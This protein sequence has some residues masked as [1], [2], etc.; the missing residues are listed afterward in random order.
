MAVSIYIPTNREEDSLFCIPSPTFIVCRFF[1]D[2]HS[3]L[4]DE[5]LIVVLISISLIISGGEH[6]FMCCWPFVCLRRNV[7]SD[8]WTTVEL[9]CW[10]L[11]SILDIKP[12]AGLWFANIFCHYLGCHL[13]LLRMSCDTRK[14][15]IFF[16]DQCI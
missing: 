1:D 15:L 4:C 12:E 9:C 10:L 2:G 6:L 14:F 5:Y 7:C 3:D 13:T 8:F 16:E 11:L